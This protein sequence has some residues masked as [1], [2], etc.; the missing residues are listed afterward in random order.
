MR[1]LKSSNF[2]VFDGSFF[3]CFYAND[4]YWSVF[5]DPDFTDYPVA[6]VSAVG[7]KYIWTN[8]VI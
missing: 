4:E 3:H 2:Y 1:F 6:I 7:E 8:R 5:S